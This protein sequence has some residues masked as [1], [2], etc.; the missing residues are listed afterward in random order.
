MRSRA[1]AGLVGLV[2]FLVSSVWFLLTWRWGFDLADEG[3]YWYGAQHMLAGEWPLYDFA[4]YDI[5]RYAWA[6]TWMWLLDDSGIFVARLA[7][8]AMLFPAWVYIVWKCVRALPEPR[9]TGWICAWTVVATLLLAIWVRPYYKSADFVG[10]LM[11]VAALDLLIS[12]RIDRQVFG[13]GCLVGLAAIIGRNHGLYGVAGAVLSAC[14][15]L[16]RGEPLVRL[17]RIARVFTLGVICG[18]GPNLLLM[19]LVPNYLEGF[20]LSIRQLFELGS[21]NISA[22][23]PWP[24]TLP[25]A[26]GGIIYT[27]LCDLGEAVAFVMVALVPVW[28]CLVLLPAQN[29]RSPILPSNSF[30]LACMLASLPYSHYAFSRADLTHLSLSAYPLML[31]CLVMPLG[32]PAVRAAGLLLLSL[33]IFAS[34]HPALSMGILGRPH[35]TISVY[36]SKIEAPASV[37]QR[38][39]GV[40]R[41]LN[42]LKAESFVALPDMP[43]LHAMMKE[44]M[45]LRDIYVLFRRS[46]A[47][48]EKE[49]SRLERNPPQVIV[50]S[51]ALLQNQKQ[52][53]FARL[54]PV[55]HAWITQHYEL[56]RVPDQAVDLQFWKQ[57]PVGE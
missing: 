12:S 29:R 30:F 31:A 50:I 6:A 49:I 21:T 22:P 34:N 13:A 11:V 41:G 3:F 37:E 5:G 52:M 27:S 47:Y 57:K 46:D 4:A 43:T 26:E 45:R 38:T 1:Q 16:V 2:C 40:L 8:Q 23:A 25:W 33:W 18:F 9:S 14:F 28:V 7:A 55:I 32:R 54:A 53:S 17:Q 39:S 24:W 19:A 44:P 48:Q 15:L 20:L 10:C 42:A 36:S 51:T 56:V 35:R